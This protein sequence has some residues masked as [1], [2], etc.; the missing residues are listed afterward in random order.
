MLTREQIENEVNNFL[1]TLERMESF[2]IID[3]KERAKLRTNIKAWAYD[4]HQ[5]TTIQGEET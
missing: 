2:G 5:L 1:I 3:R 4:E